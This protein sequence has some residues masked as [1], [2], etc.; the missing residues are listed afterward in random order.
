[1]LR[2]THLTGLLRTAAAA[3]LAAVLLPGAAA[4]D[5][6]WIDAP[7][8]AP[9]NAPGMA[10]PEAPAFNDPGFPDNRC[11]HDERPAETFED[12]AV[13]AAG[14]HL[15]GAY[16]GGWGTY[17]VSGLAGYDGMCRPLSYNYFVFVDGQFA[18]TLSPTPMDS[19][20]DSS[21]FGPTLF[22]DTINMR[23]SRYTEQDPLCCPSSSSFVQF[24]IEHQ[25]P[26]PVV[27]ATTANTQPNEMPQ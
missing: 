22:G 1:M 26:G 10:V 20:V 19:R 13:A 25:G 15:Y 3:G 21:G 17:I 9:W 4:A 16:T 8:I 11:G 14:W 5:G 6:S 23:F 7:T 2:R 24:K 12:N 27:Y 18:G